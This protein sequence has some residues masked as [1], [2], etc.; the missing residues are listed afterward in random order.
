M[1]SRA[2]DFSRAIFQLF[3]TIGFDRATEHLL[4]SVEYDYARAIG[5]VALVRIVADMIR[6]THTANGRHVRTDHPKPGQ[7]GYVELEHFPFVSEVARVRVSQLA[8]RG[9]C[10]AVCDAIAAKLAAA[11]P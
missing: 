4:T 2:S 10:S 1:K 6:A 7:S 5:E 9:R 11:A 8:E 3:D